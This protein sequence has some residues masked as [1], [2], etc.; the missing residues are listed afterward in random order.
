MTS[1]LRSRPQKGMALIEVLVSILIFSVGILGLIGLQ[2]RAI[3]LSGDAED[4]NRA[5]LL[6]NELISEMWLRRT[7]SLP[8]E[9]KTAWRAKVADMG[10]NKGGL[11]NGDGNY[12]VTGRQADVTITWQSPGAATQSKLTTRVVLP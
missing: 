2:S 10:P 1:A 7:P 6:A 12:Q 8:A 4:R 5:A 3:Q 11:P 9:F